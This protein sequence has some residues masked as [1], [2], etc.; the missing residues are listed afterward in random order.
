[1]AESRRCGYC[2]QVG[3]RVTD[4][5]QKNGERDLIKRHWL[6]E[7]IAIYQAICKIGL[8]PGAMLREGENSL[9]QVLDYN[10][11]FRRQSWGGHSFESSF[12]REM[13]INGSDLITYKKVKY[14][15]QVH[16]SLNSPMPEGM[17]R[18]ADRY[19]RNGMHFYVSIP[20]LSLKNGGQVMP[21]RTNISMMM[22]YK[23]R[24]S[25]GNSDDSY[26]FVNGKRDYNKVVVDPSY[27]CPT[28]I[29]PDDMHIT[30]DYLHER[31]R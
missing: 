7:P 5:V 24:L 16:F 9:Y 28:L 3:H 11:S 1:M 10:T 31:L 2:R 6:S 30:E 21:Y 13:M 26:G 20:T 8:G 22:L 19:H 12:L 4:C 27:E 15:K 23:W 18:T 29:M 25:N 14:S 17:I